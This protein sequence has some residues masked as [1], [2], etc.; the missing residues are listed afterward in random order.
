MTRLTVAATP[1]VGVIKREDEIDVVGAGR[2]QHVH[3]SETVSNTSEDKIR[4]HWESGGRTGRASALW[5]ST[6][7]HLRNCVEDQAILQIADGVVRDADLKHIV[8]SPLGPTRSRQAGGVYV[9]S[10]AAVAHEAVVDLTPDT[11]S[12]DSIP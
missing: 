5:Q 8:W 6:A 12:S 9:P 10:S 7:G 4:V 2:R 3:I 1:G 11:R